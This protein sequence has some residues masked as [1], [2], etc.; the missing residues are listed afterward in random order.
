MA[1]DL[2]QL[3]VKIRFLRESREWS[4]QKLADETGLSKPYLSSLENGE[5]GRPNIEY[6]YQV[7]QALNTTIDDLLEPL[8]ATAKKNSISKV[9]KQDLPE[10]LRLFIEEEQLSDE[11]A[12]MLA[13]VQYRGHRP[14]DKDGWR[15][16]YDAIRFGTRRTNEQG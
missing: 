10:S 16:I 14:K 2:K 9:Q 15:L 11:D 5:G 8:G 6:L 3:G 4:L 7:A 13:T 1:I 12:A